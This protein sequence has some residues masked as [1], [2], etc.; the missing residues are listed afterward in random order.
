MTEQDLI[1]LGF[2]KEYGDSFSYYTLDLGTDYE[3]LC[4]ISNADDETEN[5]EWSVFLFN[6]E[7][8]KYTSRF[9]LENLIRNLKYNTQT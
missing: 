2:E 3:K 7:S 4:L 1:E 6:Y 5:G 9:Q 8:F